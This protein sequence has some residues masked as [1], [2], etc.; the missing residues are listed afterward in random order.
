[1]SLDN[2]YKDYILAEKSIDDILT[3]FKAKF[4]EFSAYTDEI[5]TEYIDDTFFITPNYF[6]RLGFDI[7]YKGL[8]YSM[9]HLL[10]V[11]GLQ[12]DGSLNSADDRLTTSMSAGGVSVSYSK[13]A[14]ESLSEYEYFFGNTN[15]GKY[16]LMMLKL[17]G[18]GAS[19]GG[20][21]V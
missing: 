11:L 2:I 1:M 12:A 6:L 13:L 21:V 14:N 5:L 3:D 8:L 17:N 4:V 20:A 7:S 10:V 9:A 19:L 15:Y 16:V 18:F